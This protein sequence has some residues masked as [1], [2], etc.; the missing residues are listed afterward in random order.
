MSRH[1]RTGRQ[2]IDRAFGLLARQLPGPASRAVQWLHRPQS[3]YVRI[4]LGLLLMGASFFA[5]LPV[6]GIEMLPL[7][8]L[9]VAQDIPGL[10][11]PVAR[12]VLWLILQ[13]LKAR[14]RWRRRHI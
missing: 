3:R 10:R 7:G 14:R 5:V 11:G 13:F 12:M 8:L 4:P 6:F 9:L 2:E 1:Q